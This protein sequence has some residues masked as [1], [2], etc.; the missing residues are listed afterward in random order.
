[1]YIYYGTQYHKILCFYSN[2]HIFPSP[3]TFQIFMDTIALRLLFIL[4]INGFFRI[5]SPNVY[6]LCQ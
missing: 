6:F 2:F 4:I 5:T 1:M 3:Q